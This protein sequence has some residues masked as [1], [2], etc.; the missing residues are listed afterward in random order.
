MAEE[1][2]VGYTRWRL[3][4]GWRF[5]RARLCMHRGTS[6]RSVS[7]PR[8]QIVVV[9]LIGGM[10]LGGGWTP[11]RAALPDARVYELVSPSNKNGNDVLVDS[12]RTRTAADGSAIQFPSL[13]GFGDVQGMSFAT[14]YL[15][16]RNPATGE[17]TT[18]GITPLQVPQKA[19]SVV[20]AG[21]DLRYV[22]EFSADLEQGVFLSNRLLTAPDGANVQGVPNLYLRRDLR[23]PG[24]GEYVLL[25]DAPAAA[26]AHLSYFPWFAGASNDFV[27]VVFSSTLRLTA[28]AP[29]QPNPLFCTF[30]GS[31]E[32]YLYEWVE[33]SGVR[34]VG[35]LP[36]EEGGGPAVRSI[37]GSAW[38]ASRYAPHVVSEDGSRVFFTVADAAGESSGRI[39]MR[40]NGSE[41]IRV[42]ESEREEPE[43]EQRARYETASADGRFVFFTTREGLTEDDTDANRDLYRADMDAAPGA[44]L[45]RVSIDSEPIDGDE[46]VLRVLAASADG[47]KVFFVGFTQLVEGESL[48]PPNGEIMLFAWHNGETE[49]VGNVSNDDA[50][51]HSTEGGWNLGHKMVR[52]TPD[53]R[54][55][56]FTSRSQVGLTGADPG[57]CADLFTGCREVY[58]YDS[59][60]DDLKCASCRRGGGPALADAT[61]MTR[62]SLGATSSG[63]SLPQAITNDGQRVFFTT[64]DPLL[65][66]DQNGLVEDVYMYDVLNDKVH[67]ISSGKSTSGS[68]FVGASTSGTSLFFV[69]RERL[70][71]NDIDGNYDI[72]DARV[73]GRFVPFPA[74]K[75]C[76][77]ERC[78]GSIPAAPSGEVPSS[79]GLAGP[80]DERVDVTP[81]FVV[82]HLS[83]RA[84]RRLTAGRSGQVRLRVS[85]PGRVSVHLRARIDGRV[86][87]VSST[88]KRVPSGGI[89]RLTLRLSRRALAQLGASGR[90]QLT[91][92]VAYSQVAHL[93]RERVTLVAKD[94]RR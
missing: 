15:S 43:V 53:G 86:R 7:I 68:F 47:E 51:D 5:R 19:A 24:P 58:V 38:R 87:A 82:R 16:Q 64:G 49:F 54:F 6:A 20:A 35:I 77:E 17:W 37:A 59:L 8:Q 79:E 81:W 32:R 55:L 76:N 46:D 10:L 63:P 66:E 28:N 83:D 88:S 1:T 2:V 23:T 84:K 33:G 27:H 9:L 31:C 30:F 80:E 22:S 94:P 61:I 71:G 91:V 56:L 67:L 85:D 3:T 74:P 36:D 34:L 21:I 29:A 18:H 69:T 13:G 65:P 40:L 92:V 70:A 73:N 42:N 48:R 89:T 75:T 26:A 90:L 52:V 78:Q 50:I 25:T 93:V 60:L 4:D 12:G 62:V 45:T 57:A 39:Y 14:E 41:T 72:Y 11:A 44:R